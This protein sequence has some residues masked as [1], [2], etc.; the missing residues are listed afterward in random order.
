MEVASVL[1]LTLDTPSAYGASRLLVRRAKGQLCPIRPFR[2]T[3]I[4]GRGMGTVCDWP[5]NGRHAAVSNSKPIDH[6]AKG[7]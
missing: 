3:P 7:T 1:H 5:R 4:G 2:Q 6:P